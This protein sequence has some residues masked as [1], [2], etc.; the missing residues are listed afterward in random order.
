M[1]MDV[2]FDVETFCTITDTDRAALE[3]HGSNIP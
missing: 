1:L 2:T 3:Y